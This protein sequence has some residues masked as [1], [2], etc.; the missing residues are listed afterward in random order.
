MSTMPTNDS[1]DAHPAERSAVTPP[2]G[3]SAWRQAGRALRLL[4][5]ILVLL[6]A[7]LGV[8]WM[9]QHRVSAKRR[10]P[11]KRAVLVKVT[12]VRF[13]RQRVTVRAMGKVGPARE[14]DLHPRVKGEVLTI[15]PNLLPGGLIR[16]GR[17][18][19]RID[20]SDYRLVVRQSASVVEQAE[21]DLRVEQGRQT[22]ARR[23]FQL[24]GKMA[25]GGDRDL[26]LR[27][28]QLRKAQAT[29]EAARAALRKARLDLG[30]TTI[31]A[32]FN[33]VIQSRG[34]DIGTRVTEASSLAKL[35]GTD[36]FW[37]ELVV[38]VDRLRWIRIPTSNSDSGAVVRIRDR[39]AWGADAFRTGRVIRLAPDLEERGRMA[40][41]IVG[42]D[43]PLALQ[44]TQAGGPR[45]L[46]G[47]YV[48]AEIEGRELSS[49]AVVQRRLIR[50]GDKVWLIDARGRLDIRPVKIAFRG[51]ARVLVTGGIRSG[52]RVV[53]TDLATPVQGMVL[54]VVRGSA[55]SKGPPGARG[56]RSGG[57]MGR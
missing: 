16:K 44:A 18:L 46:L 21:A 30:R 34:V 31:R 7:G 13:G 4:L 41:L 53:T 19:L 26:V 52:D 5:P 40:R 56:T 14:V 29:L 10:K 47:S 28:P 22:V 49:V 32:P 8:R 48:E 50:D 38:P 39:A 24:L 57:G 42:V 23:E 27:G 12:T 33:A 17:I 3:P 1:R 43:D 54:R 37:V 36:A 15:S 9:L 11:P 2:A 20:S 6:G 45:L 55:S 35:V 51:P 25:K